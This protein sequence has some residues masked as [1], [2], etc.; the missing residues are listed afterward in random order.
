MGLEM[1]L[2]EIKLEGQGLTMAKLQTALI[3]LTIP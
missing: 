2:E 3:H 1:D